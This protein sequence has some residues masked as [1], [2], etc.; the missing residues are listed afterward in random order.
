MTRQSRMLM[1]LAFVAAVAIAFGAVY[2]IRAPDGN[3]KS[4]LQ[5]DGSPELLARLK[6]LNIGHLAAF[7]IAEEPVFVGDLTFADGAGA[8]TGLGDHR[9]QTVLLSV[10][11][12]WC[13]PCRE[14][15]P[16][17]VELQNSLG[18]ASFQVLPVSVD[19]GDD[20]K[21]KKFYADNGLDGALPFRHDGT[22][23]T[24]NTLKKRSIAFGM[25]VSVLVDP[26][27]CA[28]GWINGPADWT[29]EEAGR[30]V[31]AVSAKR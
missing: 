25:P 16:T 2:G 24:F 1:V 18:S 15:M 27:G 14:E 10:W 4:A 26:Q 21:P 28:L 20:A 22:L 6:D 11:A 29:S 30:L 13:V 7:Q 5:C 8:A 23:A 9:G 12:T 19:S 31:T 17:F 3:D